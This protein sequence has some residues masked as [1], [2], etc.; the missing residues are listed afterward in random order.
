MSLLHCLILGR[1][2]SIGLFVGMALMYISAVLCRA[3]DEKPRKYWVYV[4]T[5]T[6]G[7]SSSKGIYRFELNPATGELSARALA[8]ETK[9]PSFLAIHPNHRFIYAVGELDTFQG[10]NSGAISAF[11][12]DPRTGNL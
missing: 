10:K 7:P 11:A 8:A 12:I 4:G 6:G 1:P 9:N 3:E 5:Y 2:G